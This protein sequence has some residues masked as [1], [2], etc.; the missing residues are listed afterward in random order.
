VT[1]PI[2]WE[3]KYDK[4]YEVNLGCLPFPTDERTNNSHIYYKIYLVIYQYIRQLLLLKR[5]VSMAVTYYLKNV[6]KEK[7]ITIQIYSYAI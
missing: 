6:I 5:Y 4:T 3:R 1:R 7:S 2:T